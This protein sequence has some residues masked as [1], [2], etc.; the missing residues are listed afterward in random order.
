[1]L[2]QCPAKALKHYKIFGG[3][4][5]PLNMV[6][7]LYCPHR[8]HYVLWFIIACFALSQSLLSCKASTLCNILCYGSEVKALI[9]LIMI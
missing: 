5:E 4:K 9:G 3:K 1:M 7:T 6:A 8:E 2:A